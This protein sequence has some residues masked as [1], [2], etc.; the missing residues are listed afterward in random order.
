[1]GKDQI[2]GRFLEKENEKKRT[3][4]EESEG[5]KQR[6]RRQI[7]SGKSLDVQQASWV[8]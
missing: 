6:R 7:L 8:A 1:L 5:E 4:S 2:K 3:S